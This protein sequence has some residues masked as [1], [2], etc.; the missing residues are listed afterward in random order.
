MVLCVSSHPITGPKT[1]TNLPYRHVESS[2][3]TADVKGQVVLGNE[4][5]EVP[6]GEEPKL[7]VRTWLVLNTNTKVVES[8]PM[9]T[10]IHGSKKKQM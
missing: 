2:K 10:I 1:A 6:L 5:T 7:N 3:T 4:N 9:H 8:V